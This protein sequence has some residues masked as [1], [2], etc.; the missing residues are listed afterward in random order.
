MA[1]S[2]LLGMVV[3]VIV[4]IALITLLNSAINRIS[5]AA[6]G[7]ATDVAISGV[8]CFVTGLIAGSWMNWKG[9]SYGA[10]AAFIVRILSTVL[11]VVW[12][13]T[14]SGMFPRYI[15]TVDIIDWALWGFGA[16]MGA[17][18]GFVGERIRGFQAEKQ[19]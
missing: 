3:S 16:I 9:A 10:S 18:G 1:E 17:L 11:G 7:L 14:A 5:P 2:R 8:S 13:I 6:T 15:P 4:G 12:F 19:K